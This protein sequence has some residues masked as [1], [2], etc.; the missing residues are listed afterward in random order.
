MHVL[1]HHDIASNHKKI[2]EA[3]ALQR[4]FKEIHG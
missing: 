1:R 4:V 3:D 2:A